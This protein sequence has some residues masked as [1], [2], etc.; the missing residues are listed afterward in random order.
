MWLGYIWANVSNSSRPHLTADECLLAVYRQSLVLDQVVQ[1]FTYTQW[2]LLH[3][4]DYYLNFRHETFQPLSFSFSFWFLVTQERPF[5][6]RKWNIDQED[7]GNLIILRRKEGREIMVGG[8][9]K[10]GGE[11]SMEIEI[12]TSE[13][14]K[15]G[16][17]VGRFSFQILP[18]HVKSKDRE[19]EGGMR[20]W[21]SLSSDLLCAS[22]ARRWH[23]DIF[24]RD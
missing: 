2:S 1:P 13:Q 11:G 20:A 4:R 23:R 3:V 21:M 9:P 7:V 8:R 12:Y 14:S 18:G 5:W 15:R 16:W 10:K 17:E 22:A 6:K 19:T 24:V